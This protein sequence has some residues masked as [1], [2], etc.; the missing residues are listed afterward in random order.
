MGADLVPRAWQRLGRIICFLVVLTVLAA[1]SQD[2]GHK[3]PQGTPSANVPCA[4]GALVL[5]PVVCIRAEPGQHPNGTWTY[6]LSNP[7]AARLHPGSIL[8]V[9]R[10]SVR[11]VESVQRAGDHVTFTTA[12]VPLTEVVKDGT[13]P[14]NASITPNSIDKTVD[15]PPPGPPPEPQTTISPTPSQSTTSPAPPV[16]PVISASIRTIR[17]VY[18]GPC[19][20]A[21]AGQGPTFEATISVSGGPVAVAYHWTLTDPKGSATPIPGRLSFRG[22]GPQTQTADYSVPVDQYGPDTGNEGTISLQVDSPSIAAAPEQLPY[23]VDCS[24]A[25]PSPSGVAYGNRLV[26]DR[27]ANLLAHTFPL[28]DGY[29]IEPSLRLGKDSFLIDVIASR[30]TG[31][32]KLTWKVHGE[33]EDFLSG[34]ALRIVSHRLRDSGLHTTRLRGQLRFS[35][36]LS[37]AVPDAVLNR[38]SLDLPI[39][40]FVQPLLVGDFPVFLAVDIH[41]HIGPEFTPGQALHGYASVSFS[42]GQ[43]FRIH[44]RAIDRPRGPSI[45]GLRLD[46]GI[47]DLL[48]LPTL[49]ASV[50][51]PYLSLGDDFYSAGAW[52]WASPRM[53]VSIVPGHDPDLCARAETA[54]S[55]S[56]GTKFQ[57]FGLRQTLSTQVYD[58]PL[59]PAVSF[60]Q[61]PECLTG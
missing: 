58:H 21:S 14:L 49:K 50:D 57:L 18:R 60:P 9:A 53:G 8:V 36:S 37:V 44:L 28:V 7:K 16:T 52:L 27:P 30:Q 19:S 15:L 41:L 3:K 2:C 31:P 1:F 47:R 39:R 13:I 26:R 55:A 51:F 32:A 33:L 48:R 22:T 38:L 5:V 4:F 54:A 61:S 25:S 43:G 20:A 46:P 56:V 10:K 34:G 29:Q 23:H 59:L 24:P 40:L 35:W 42:G 6:P 17:G 11:R 45:G 12:A